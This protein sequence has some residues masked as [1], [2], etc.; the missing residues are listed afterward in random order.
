M[1]KIVHSL[2]MFF[3]QSGEINWDDLERYLNEMLDAGIETIYSMAYNT[4]YMQMTANEIATLHKFV[5]DVTKKA[6]V[7][8]IIGHPFLSTKPELDDYFLQIKDI[9]EKVSAV[10]ML[11]PERYYGDNKV[12]ED[13]IDFPK[14]YGMRTL[15][16]EMK[17]VSG[18][19]GELIEWPEDLLFRLLERPNVMGV[20][21]DSKNDDVTTGLIEHFG[22][23]KNIIVAGHG[24][25]RTL[26]LAASQGNGF[27]WLNGS[28]MISPALGVKFCSVLNDE[29]ADGG[30]ITKYI[31]DFE[32][33]FFHFVKR[34]GWHMAHKA[35]LAQRGY[36]VHERFPL[37]AAKIHMDVADEEA[38]MK[39]TNFL[40]Q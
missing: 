32:E 4:R 33:P 40:S 30:F 17:L 15:I 21:E 28:S 11:Y 38:M 27:S 2:P 23:D 35:M 8:L 20:K 29:G 37:P 3:T 12:I 1:Y 34:Y 31:E 39:I 18:F 6:D 7:Q 19:N 13:F 24:K 10:S 9:A 22:K 36:S 16:H 5:V 25:R 14:K 26:N